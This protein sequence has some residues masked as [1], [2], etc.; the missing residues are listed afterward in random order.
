MSKVHALLLG[1]AA[2]HWTLKSSI[3]LYVTKILRLRQF[4]TLNSADNQNHWFTDVSK[5]SKL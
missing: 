2:K 4:Q 1:V 3:G 5:G